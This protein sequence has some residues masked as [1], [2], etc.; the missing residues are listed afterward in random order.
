M[1]NIYHYY[2]LLTRIA[3]YM[4]V[5]HNIIIITHFYSRMN[6]PYWRIVIAQTGKL[7]Y[8]LIRN[9]YYYYCGTNKK[10]KKRLKLL[11]LNITIMIACVTGNREISIPK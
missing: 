2:Y 5:L 10:N 11:R 1:L 8:F 7:C 4:F 6:E 9:Y 3:S